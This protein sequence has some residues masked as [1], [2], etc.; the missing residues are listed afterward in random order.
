[1]SRAEKWTIAAIAAIAA[2]V[3]VVVAIAVKAFAVVSELPERRDFV[4]RELAEAVLEGDGR[5]RLDVLVTRLRDDPMTPRA[6][7]YYYAAV[8]GRV[9]LVDSVAGDFRPGRLR[10]EP[11]RVDWSEQ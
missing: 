5:L 7:R 4:V 1:M 10:R 11:D 2:V 8:E 3:L 6:V 9:A